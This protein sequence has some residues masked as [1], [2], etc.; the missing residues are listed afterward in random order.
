MCIKKTLFER[1]YKS[2]FLRFSCFL[3][4]CSISVFDDF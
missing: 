3:I 1:D 2:F 4:N